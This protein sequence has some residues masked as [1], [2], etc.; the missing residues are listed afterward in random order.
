LLARILAGACLL[1]GLSAF[2][3][4]WYWRDNRS[5]P[6]LKT[7]SDMMRQ[8][9]YVDAA[10]VLGEHLRRSPYDG[11]AR[12]ML[13]R[14]LAARGD[15]LGCARQLHEVPQWWPRKA[16]ALLREGQAF[17][18]IDRAKDA[19]SAW[20]ELIKDDPLHPV[21]AD[22]FHDGCQELLK[23]YAIGDRWEDAYPVM[24][25]A[26]DHAAPADR[27]VLLAMRM[28]PELE[29]VSQKE[30]L[31]VLKRYVA[32]AA[33]DWEAFRAL[34]RAELGLGQHT[35]AARHFQA[36]LKGRPDDV[37]AWRDYLTMLLEQGDLD[38]FLT[39]LDKAPKS[40]ES[41]PETWL[42]RGVAKEKVGQWRSAADCFH[43]A[44]E[45]NP[46]VPK[47][48]YRLAM[49]EER[50]GHREEATAHRQRTKTMNEARARLPTAYSAYF[51]A[52]APEKPGAPDLPSACKQLASI[53][54][55]LGWAR[56]AQAWDRLAV[57]P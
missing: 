19:E 52:R 9:Q 31:E 30:S 23:L 5:L 36:C 38:T 4:W 55:T 35:E 43:K 24:W 14:A 49:I 3:V 12:M 11:E 56:A 13:A 48:Y 46:Y 20:L 10:S 28:R 8:E 45:L 51:A 17:L 37:R 26:Y 25:T 27:P 34:A 39:L 29:R 47:Y 57:S 33:D 41:E 42:F 2:N 53:C 54:E 21:A 50:L 15:L 1:A 40:A 32:A 16:E 7:I 6:H 18:Q 44:I 22:I